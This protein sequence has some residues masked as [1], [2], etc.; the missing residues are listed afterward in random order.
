MRSVDQDAFVKITERTESYGRETPAWRLMS[1]DA[2]F[3][4]I[5]YKTDRARVTKDLYK[6]YDDLL[7][8]IN[9]LRFVGVLIKEELERQKPK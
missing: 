8:S 4:G 5:I 1:V 6:K 2:M 7:D 9:Y 3:G